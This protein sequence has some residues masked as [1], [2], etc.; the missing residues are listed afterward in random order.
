MRCLEFWSEKLTSFNYD[1]PAE[2]FPN[3]GHSKAGAASG[4]LRFTNAADAIR[5]AVEVLRD[6]DIGEAI[7]EVNGEQFDFD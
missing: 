6:Q 4:N 3:S 1:N 5:Y 7:L 2:L